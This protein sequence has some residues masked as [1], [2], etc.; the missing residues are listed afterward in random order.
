MPQLDQTLQST[1]LRSL[2]YGDAK[3][4]K[5]WWAL[6]AAEAGFNVL[7]L[8]LEDGS[9]IGRMINTEAQRNVSVVKCHDRM[10]NSAAGIFLTMFLR[11]TRFMWDEQACES[12]MFPNA[13]KDGH[14]FFAFDPNKLTPNDVVIIDSWTSNCMSL[15][16]RW[17]AEN[18]ID[19]SNAEQALQSNWDLYRWAGALADWELAQMHALPCHVILIGHAN[20]YEK[21]KST[22]DANNK[23]I[24]VVES[25]RIQPFSVS[26]PHAPKIE[27]SFTDIFYFQM[28]GNTIKIDTN[29]KS[30]RAGGSRVVPPGLY[31]FDKFQFKDLCAIANIPMPVDAPP[32]EGWQWYGSK[33]E[34]VAAASPQAKPKQQLAIP[35][36][37]QK[38]A[39]MTNL[40]K[41]E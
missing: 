20:S 21:K 25:T 30:D 32:S 3:R 18:N 14:S 40:M 9:Q 34:L 17:C 26:N 22:L 5:T 27:K 35:S 19:V 12:V 41:Q 8:D 23:K 2:I 37:G 11:G 24:E 31:D 10:Q 38:P 6:T 7:D 4:K 29:S 36:A 39:A 15:A 1:L 13:A 33:E 16:K 28:F